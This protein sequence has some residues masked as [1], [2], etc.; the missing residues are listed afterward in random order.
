MAHS[1]TLGKIHKLARRETNPFEG[2]KFGCGAPENTDPK[3]DEHIQS[4][5]KAERERLADLGQKLSIT[6]S[7]G[8]SGNTHALTDSQL[9]AQQPKTVQV[10]WHVIHD[11]PEGDLTPDQIKAQMDV[12]NNDFKDAGFVFNLQESKKV[13]NKEWSREISGITPLHLEMEKALHKGDMK[14][15]NLYSLKIKPGPQGFTTGFSQYPWV[16]QQRGLFHDAVVIHY[17]TVPGVFQKDYEVNHGKALTHESGH[18]FGLKHVFENVCNAP[19][20]SVD[21]TPPQ[22]GPSDGC[23]TTAPDTCPGGGVDSIHNHMDY[24]VD[25]CKTEFTEGQIVRMQA[26]AKE[27]R[28]L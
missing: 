8:E 25:R 27:Y 19:G 26:I 5:V 14:T 9:L 7:Q 22:A 17:A 10:V 21:D 20:D 24:T 11:G 18:W 1:T 28:G 23:P 16:V 13:E 6:S 3:V 12:L 4:L 15:L 2:S